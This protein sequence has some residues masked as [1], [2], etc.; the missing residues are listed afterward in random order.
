[1]G[2][3]VDVQLQR[4]LDIKENH[5]PRHE[6][7]TPEL[8]D[9]VYVQAGTSFISS[10]NPQT[11]LFDPA[12]MKQICDLL[13][14]ILFEYCIHDVSRYFKWRVWWIPSLLVIHHENDERNSY[15]KTHVGVCHAH[16]KRAAYVFD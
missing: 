10:M 13:K 8:Q 15:A 7:R 4:D 3:V 6:R 2:W 12:G 14:K 11:A 9:G 16:E 5:S 1:M